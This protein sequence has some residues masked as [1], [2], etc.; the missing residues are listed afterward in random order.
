MTDK[1]RLVWI[2]MEMTGLDP[3][4]HVVIEIATIVTD[5]DL[6]ILAEGPVIAIRRSDEEM[7][8]IDDW[9]LHTHEASGL[10]KRVQESPYG[11]SDAE[12]ET[13]RFLTQWV[14]A[15]KVPLCGN[16]VHQD[17]LFIARE[18]PA[19]NAHLHYRI[20]DVSSIKE[21]VTRW[22]PDSLRPPSKKRAHTA[23]EDI[24]ESIN[25]LRWYRQHI[26]RDK[27]RESGA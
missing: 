19:L 1:D 21:L 7:D 17:R 13:M 2:D 22:Y 24:R 11:I 23:L 16:S 20:V 14:P 15:G 26:F 25:E 4:R 10:L 9:S 18:M 8:R 12:R 27:L 3:I 6:S 5:A